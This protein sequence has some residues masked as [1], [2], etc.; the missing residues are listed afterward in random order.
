MMKD[1]GE[2]MTY[3]SL[4]YPFF[5]QENN[6]SGSPSQEYSSH[7]SQPEMD[8]MPTYCWTGFWGGNGL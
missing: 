2:K 1:K 6:I 8:L 7:I 5:N 3:T 4:V